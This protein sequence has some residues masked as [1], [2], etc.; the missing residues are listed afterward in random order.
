MSDHSA[1][2]REGIYISKSDPTLRIS[3]I[4]V[5][6]V[7]DEDDCDGDELFYLV[8][9][10]EGEDQGDLDATEYELD[11]TEWQAFVKSEQLEYD[12]DPYLDKVQ[13]SPTLEK[14]RQML[15]QAKKND[16]S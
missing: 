6:V 14:I 12:R 15:I 10:I 16:R 2:P 9:W 11:P 1:V 5:T 3:V 13:Q 8:R 4:D 7:E